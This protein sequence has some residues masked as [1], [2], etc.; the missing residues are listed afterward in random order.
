M[1]LLDIGFHGATA[2]LT[3]NRPDQ[4]NALNDAMRLEL[5][6]AVSVLRENTSV[7]AVIL[8]GAGGHFCAGGDVKAILGRESGARNAFDTRERIRNLHRWFDDLVDFEKPVIA[9]IEGVAYGAGLSLALSADFV[10]ASAEAKFCA[11]FIRLGLVPDLGAMYLLPRLVGLVRAKELVFSGRVVDAEEAAQIGLVYAVS[12]SNVLEDALVLAARFHEAPTAALGISKL[13]MNHAFESDRQAI[14]V[15]EAMAQ[16]LCR[17]SD[18]H[19]EALG[20]FI[21]K[22]PALYQWQE[23]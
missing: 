8:Y 2:V 9:A 20:R 11:A 5:T 19:Q 4:R 23:L 7:K 17:T 18:F 13:T 3:L 15:Q 16:A 14:Y 21:N 22:L 1:A 6:H 10:L 12:K